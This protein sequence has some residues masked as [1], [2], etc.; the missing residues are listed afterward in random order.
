MRTQW[1][2]EGLVLSVVSNTC[3]G[4][5]NAHLTDRGLA[6]SVGNEDGQTLS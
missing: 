6:H 4:S 2:E 5:Q 3:I 1:P